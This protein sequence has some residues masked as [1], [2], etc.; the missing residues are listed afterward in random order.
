MAFLSLADSL[1]ILILILPPHSTHRLQPLIVGLFSPLSRAYTK[2]LD[3]YIHGGLGWINMTK[4]MFWGTFWEA[5]S[6]SFNEKNIKSAFAKTGIWPLNPT[7]TISHLPKT[8]NLPSTPSKS[9]APP[10]SITPF[11]VRGLRRLLKKDP[12]QQ[13]MEIL[14]R[15]GLRLAAKYEIQSH[16]NRGLK[17]A[18]CEE[19]KRRKR[20]KRMNLLGEKE[21]NGPQFFSPERVLAA[22]TFQKSRETAEQEEKRQKA[23][24]KEEAALKRQ[25]EEAEKQERTTQRQ[26]RQQATKEEKETEKAQKQATKREKQMQKEQERQEK[27]ALV[28][29]HKEETQARKNA[30]LT[31]VNDASSAPRSKTP[32]RRPHTIPKQAAS[33]Q[34]KV[35]RARRGHRPSAQLPIRTANS[36]ED[37]SAG[38]GD[39]EVQITNRRGCTLKTPQRYRV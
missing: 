9:I 5:W 15:A 1:R 23:I 6:R 26:L 33:T 24:A 21:T 20:G 25:Q 12:T 18:I 31:T 16:G 2:V 22:K 14:E 4:R 36:V 35:K 34:R 28:A 29:Q 8:S 32:A 7:V 27:A 30:P 19:K 38:A 11:T 39:G 10:P 13:K 17:I 37:G 3:R